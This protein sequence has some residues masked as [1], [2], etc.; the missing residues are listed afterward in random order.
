MVFVPFDMLLEIDSSTDRRLRSKIH[1]MLG[2]SDIILIHQLLGR[3]GHAI[4][5][6]DWLTFENLF[7]PDA[8]ID[9][10]GGSGTVVR[11]G[12]DAIVEWFR[13]VNHPSAHHVTNIVVD[14]TAHATGPV[15]VHSKFF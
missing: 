6:R 1:G 7:V 15:A 3:Y 13:S 4:D 2:A 5:H 10:Q 12:R 8:S 11:H 14:E 9:Y